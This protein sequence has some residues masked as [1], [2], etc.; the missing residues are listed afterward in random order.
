M[1]CSH[2]PL[3]IPPCP[4]CPYSGRW[5]YPTW[6]SSCHPPSERDK[7]LQSIHEGHQ[8]IFKCQDHACQCIYW[9]ASIETSNTPLKHALHA[10]TITHRSLN[11]HSS[12]P[13]PPNAHGN[14]LELTSC[15]LMAMSTS[16]SSTTT[17]R[18]PMSVK[19]L[20]PNAM[21]PRQYPL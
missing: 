16:S 15:T 8:G 17:Q 5:H 13:Q 1:Q 19:Y 3:P 12:Q 21:L 14:T 11:S 4:W 6:W 2:G 18:F 9:L 10:S 7:V 20:H